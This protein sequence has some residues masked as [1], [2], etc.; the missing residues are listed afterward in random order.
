MS[1]FQQWSKG[2]AA[3]RRTMVQAEVRRT[4]ED[5]R[6]ARSKELGKK[7]DLPERELTWAE[8][9]RK[10]QFSISVLLRSAYD[11]LP[12]PVKLHQWGLVEDPNCKLCGKRGTMAVSYT[13]L[14]AHETSLHLVCRLLLEK[15]E[16]PLSRMPSSA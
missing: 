14:R 12:S 8:L 1:H 11:T 15:R 2:P 5:Q 7:W 3:E 16:G 6:K 4:E 9:W 10:D 13:H